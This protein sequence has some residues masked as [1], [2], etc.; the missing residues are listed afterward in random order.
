MSKI[1]IAFNIIDADVP[2]DVILVVR[3][4]NNPTGEVFRQ[5]YPAPHE[6]T[7][8]TVDDLNP[9]MHRVQIWSTE[10][11]NTL[12]TLRGQCDID[13][14]INS[15][16]TSID[17]IQFVVN[18]GLTGPPSYDPPSHI[19]N[20]PNQPNPI[21]INPD[22]DGKQYAAFKPGYGALI[23]GQHIA[24]YP[25]GG[26]QYIDGQFFEDQEE[27][28]LMVINPFTTV[29]PSSGAG[30]PRGVIEILGDTDFDVATHR[31]MLLKVNGPGAEVLRLTMPATADIPNNMMFGV[32]TH[33]GNQRFFTIAA[34]VGSPF[35][36]GDGTFRDEIHMGRGETASFIFADNSFIIINWNGDWNR[37]GQIVKADGKLPLNCLPEIG[38]WYPQADYPRLF[39]WYINE[40]NIADI[41][42]GTQDVTPDDANKPKWIIG[43]TKFWVPDRRNLFERN[44]DNNLRR[45]GD[46]QDEQVGPHFHETGT[47]T[48]DIAEYNR[49]PIDHLARAWNVGNSNSSAGQRATT[50]LNKTIGGF[51]TSENRPKNVAVYTYRIT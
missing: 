36:L 11:G 3:E 18:R 12:G 27:Y 10:D 37:V 48:T 43:I 46:L 1:F 47:D 28:T 23:W 51:V 39:E 30:F 33:F 7:N 34:P 5:F 32:N 29:T 4:M 50:D 8:L 35:V 14:S 13:A 19:D 2:T 21:Y 26:F 9:V 49:A 40:L 6:Q 20:D 45:A 24:T 25:G 22:I 41:G 31:E 17:I 42:T 44:S 15:N 16:E 38:G